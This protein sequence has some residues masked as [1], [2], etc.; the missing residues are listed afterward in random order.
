MARSQDPDS[1]NSQWFIMFDRSVSLDR[2]YTVWGRV[3]DGMEHVDAI[4]AGSRSN[5]GAVTD[6]DKIIS[7]DVLADQS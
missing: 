3:I 7:L 1:A 6:P 4:K 2:N 5:N